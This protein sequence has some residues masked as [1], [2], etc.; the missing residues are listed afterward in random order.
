LLGDTAASPAPT[1]LRVGFF[2]YLIYTHIFFATI[3][4]VT[5][6]KNVAYLNI[7]NFRLFEISHLV[8][9]IT[10]YVLVCAPAFW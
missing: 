8:V 7:R 6:S 9:I 1:A 5:L 4:Q 3:F 2:C 10:V